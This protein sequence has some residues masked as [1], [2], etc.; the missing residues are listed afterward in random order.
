MPHNKENHIAVPNSRLN[1]LT[2]HVIQVIRFGVSR[3]S[4]KLLAWCFL[5]GAW[6]ASDVTGCDGVT[7]H[8]QYTQEYLQ[9]KSLKLSI[10][11]S[12]NEVLCNSHMY[13]R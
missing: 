9:R 4:I 10:C 3:K 13:V 8:Q 12:R 11:K 5:I 7:G 1:I 6:E 2:L